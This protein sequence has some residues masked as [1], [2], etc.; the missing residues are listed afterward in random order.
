MKRFLIV[1]F[2]L[3]SVL[4]K[5]QPDDKVIYYEDSKVKKSRV[6]LA[7][8]LNPNWT[9]RR[10]IDEGTPSGGEYQLKNDQADGSFQLNYGLDVFF[11]LGSALRIGTGFGVANADFSVQ[12]ASYYSASRPDTILVD[13]STDVSMYTIPLKLNFNTSLTDAF[14]LEVIPQVQMNL[15][16][17]YENTYTP[18]NGSAKFKDDFTDKT[19]SVT[20]TVGIA[21]GGTFKLT[22]NWGLFVRGDIR[23][24]VNPLIDEVNYPREALFNLGLNTGL[25]YSF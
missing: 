15:I 5:A 17:F 11:R 8:N 20:Y 4:A 10:L 18:Q 14:D 21:L 13:V 1:V 23:Y 22:D 25:K 9:D 6:S 16:N 24:M 12:D 19:R 2:C 7:I 3:G